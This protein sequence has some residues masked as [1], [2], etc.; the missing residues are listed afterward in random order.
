MAAKK[1]SKVESNAPMSEAQKECRRLMSAGW[2]LSHI[3]KAVGISAGAAANWVEGG[4]P[5]PGFRDPLPRP[6]S[7]PPAGKPLTNKLDAPKAKRARKEVGPE[8]LE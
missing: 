2:K 8:D 6:P 4:G 7:P 1:K 3:A 5:S